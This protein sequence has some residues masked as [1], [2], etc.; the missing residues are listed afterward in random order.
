[1]NSLALY[2][3]IAFNSFQRL[4]NSTYNRISYLTIYLRNKYLLIDYFK[5]FKTT[6]SENIF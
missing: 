5:E 2:F 4:Y 3:Y 1:M 6:Y